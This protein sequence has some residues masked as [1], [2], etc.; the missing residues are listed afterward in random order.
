MR[1]IQ[2]ILLALPHLRRNGVLQRLV[3]EPGVVHHG[4]RGRGHLVR[5][6]NVGVAVGGRLPRGLH[7][8]QVHPPV[9]GPLVDGALG[10][11]RAVVVVLLEI[12]SAKLS[13]AAQTFRVKSRVSR[14]QYTL[15]YKEST[16]ET[17]FDSKVLS[18]VD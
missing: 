12:R 7:D 11:G 13:L 3:D 16:F 4:R 8:L 15:V 1:F 10:W 17:T 6:Q 5:G 9:D 14:L 2:H 18:Q